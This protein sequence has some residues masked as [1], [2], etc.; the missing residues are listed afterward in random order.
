MQRIKYS[1]GLI[2]LVL[3]VTVLAGCGGGGGPT[4]GGPGAREGGLNPK[5]I[6]CYIEGDCCKRN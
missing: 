6:A 4:G 1:L 2:F 5:L 3:L